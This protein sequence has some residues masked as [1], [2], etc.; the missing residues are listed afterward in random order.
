MNLA[1]NLIEHKHIVTTVA[2][3]KA[4]RGYVEPLITKA[5]DNTTHS[6]RLVFSQLKNK[7]AVSILFAEVAEKIA[8]RPGGYTRVIKLEPRAGDAADM[9]L[10][11]LV[12]FSVLNGATT[13]TGK[14]AEAAGGKKRTRRGG[15][16]TKSSLTNPNVDPTKPKA[17]HKKTTPKPG[18]SN[19]PK[20]RQRRTGD[21]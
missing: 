6:R 2:K 3:A 13:E 15:S 1:I 20:V 19:A 9:A 4:L 14:A 8:T 7:E 17:D 11:E 16:A 12:D 18:G 5:K 10:I 21:S